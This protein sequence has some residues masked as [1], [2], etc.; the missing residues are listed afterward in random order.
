MSTFYGGDQ[1]TAFNSYSDYQASINTDF[2][3]YT[4]PSGKYVEAYFNE[5]T[6]SNG[7][8]KIDFAGTAF[9]YVFITDNFAETY[10]VILNAGDRIFYDHDFGFGSVQ[11][12]INIKE[13]KKP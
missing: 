9:P 12:V 11:Y 7:N 6:A 5:T 10:P 3:I 8:I 2:D 4:V 13:Y 1:L